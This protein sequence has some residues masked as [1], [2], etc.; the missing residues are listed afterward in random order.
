M[1]SEAPPQT[2]QK[3]YVGSASLGQRRLAPLRGAR[4]LPSLPKTC[5]NCHDRGLRRC[6]VAQPAWRATA[7]HLT[8]A[9]VLS[10]LVAAVPG[11][12]D[13]L[14]TVPP[15]SSGKRRATK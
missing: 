11:A 5:F 2:A 10:A 3:R 1:A 13:Y 9:G 8:A 6:L 7:A 14:Y 12:I 15:Q 4:H